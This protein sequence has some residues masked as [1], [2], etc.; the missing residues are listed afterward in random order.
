MKDTVDLT[1]NGLKYSVVCE[2]SDS[3][4]RILRDHLGLLGTKEGCGHGEC[5]SCTVVLNGEAVTACTVRKKEKI[6]GSEIEVLTGMYVK[7]ITS[8]GVLCEPTGL[9][10]PCLDV[11]VEVTVDAERVI[12][13]DGVVV[14]TGREPINVLFKNLQGRVPELYAIGDCVKPRWAYNA[15]GEGARVAI[16]L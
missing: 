13:C 15:T 3:L 11:G 5:G 7:E 1:V 16:G 9:A 4:L 10:D 14:G 8:E 12:S 6:E 2:K